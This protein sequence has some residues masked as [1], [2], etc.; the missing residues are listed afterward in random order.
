LLLSDCSASIE[1]VMK[2]ETSAPVE[3]SGGFC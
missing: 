1:S 2:S 3:M